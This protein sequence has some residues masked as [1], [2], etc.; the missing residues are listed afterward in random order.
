MATVTPILPTVPAAFARTVH[1]VAAKVHTTFPSLSGKVGVATDL[2]LHGAV[3]PD[4]ARGPL[5]FSVASQVDAF[6]FH[7]VLCGTP[8]TCT[9]EDF[10]Q[11]TTPETPYH[12]AHIVATW[13]YRR[14][15]AQCAPAPVASPACPEALFSITLKGTMGGHEVLL[16]ARGQSREEF[17][18]NVAELRGLLDTPPACPPAS[19]PAPTGQPT[20]EGW[21]GKHNVQM[22]QTTK[23]GR[24]WWSHKT[25]EGW[26]KGK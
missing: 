11:H 1:S 22:R 26:C 3:E 14:T 17:R 18:A 19:T 8:P 5:A 9:C 7:E 25:A 12:C 2:V 23:D 4:E 24:S 15:L 10:T 13:I 21:C 20:P 6:T 16:T